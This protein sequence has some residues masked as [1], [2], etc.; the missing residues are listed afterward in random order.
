M[1]YHQPVMPQL[2]L[3]YLNVAA[4][5]VYVDCTLGEGGH[6]EFLLNNQ[7]KHLIG[8][9]QDS[10]LIEIAKKRL[11]E[12]RNVSFVPGN[13]KDIDT[14]LEKKGFKQVD[15]ILFDLGISMFHF[16][17]SQKGFSFVQAQ[18][19]D[20]RLSSTGESA[21]DIVNSYSEERL[22]DLIYHYGE[23]R[24][25]RRIAKRIVET[26]KRNPIVT[27]S[28]LAELIVRAVPPG[29]I[30]RKIHPATRTFQ[31]LRI[32]VNSELKNLETALEKAIRILSPD[33]RIC[34]ISYHSLEDRIVKYLFRKYHRSEDS[35]IKIEILTKK[36]IRPEYEEVRNNKSARSAKLR[37][38]RR[39]R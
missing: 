25:S 35:D 2:V 19:L 26:R 29:K 15:G 21:F 38:A 37:A 34:V 36:P 23:E 7:I 8:I 24:F 16:K 30:H 27:T 12:F 17:Q 10:E 22:A 3:K 14:L 11:K 4:D 32:A 33:G 1:F 18:K 5:K 13:F 31:A 6:S 28:E 9:E 39:I 20:M